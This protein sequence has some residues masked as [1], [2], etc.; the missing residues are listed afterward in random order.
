MP[1]SS[2]SGRTVLVTRPRAQADS[3]VQELESLG[4]TIFVMPVIEIQ[5]PLSFEPLDRALNSLDTYDWVVLTSVNGVRAVSSRMAE[6]GIPVEKLSSRRLATIGPATAAELAH[7]A[8]QPDLVP[9]EYVSEAIA[10][11]VKGLVELPTEAGKPRFLLARADIA[12]RD[13][14]ELLRGLGAEV[15][16]VA[17]YR[18]VRSVGAVDLP[19]AAPDY[20]TLTS[21]SAARGTHEILAENGRLGWM[22]ESRL[23]CIGPITSAT[24][25]EMGFGVAAQASEY[26]VPGVVKALLDDAKSLVPEETH[27]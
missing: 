14:A 26:T 27:A 13:L 10:E 18:I 17:A 4:A 8:R 22:S 1:K 3:L 21:S 16:E 11:T 20:I 24:V 15:D 19:E 2:L 25:T 6:L 9:A 23:V 12:R 5:P 7:F